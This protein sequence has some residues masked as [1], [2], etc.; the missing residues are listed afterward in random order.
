M[1]KVT[2]IVFPHAIFITVL[3]QIVTEVELEAGSVSFPQW[4]VLYGDALW[5]ESQPS[6]CW[7]GGPE[8]V[9][10]AEDHSIL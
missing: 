3:K 8:L 7:G 10:R 2:L 4:T 6:Q 9:G 5:R 1:K